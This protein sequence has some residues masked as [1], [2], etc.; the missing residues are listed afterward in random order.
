MA[1]LGFSDRDRDRIDRLRQNADELSAHYL[2]SAFELPARLY[3][4]EILNWVQSMA[5]LE[6]RR[7]L[8]TAEEHCL[9][10]GLIALVDGA[11]VRSAGREEVERRY[12]SNVFG[13]PGLSIEAAI[14]REAR[15]LRLNMPDYL[16]H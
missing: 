16:R 10:P 6:G 15:A 8:E 5:A 11:E 3:A 2:H 4:D 13:L 1:Q 7:P 14:E 12:L 9:H